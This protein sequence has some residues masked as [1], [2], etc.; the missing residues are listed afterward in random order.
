MRLYWFL[1][2]FLL[3]SWPAQAKERY[4]IAIIDTGFDRNPAL[5]PYECDKLSLD[6]T[7]TDGLDRI[8]HGSHVVSLA[9]ADLNPAEWCFVMIKWINHDGDDVQETIP[10]AINY[11]VSIGAKIINLSLGGR[12][13]GPKEKAAI[14]RALRAGI[15]VVVAAGNEQANLDLICGYFPA[16][17][18]FRSRFFHVVASPHRSSNRGGTVTETYNGTCFYAGYRDEGT[19][20]AAGRATNAIAR[21]RH[22]H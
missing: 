12:Y 22:V 1:A 3:A 18:P 8:H 20:Y 16:C 19:S 10:K 21:G 5:L 9:M 15:H 6:L 13:D 11:A 4:R 17:Y 2:F 7:G 14:L